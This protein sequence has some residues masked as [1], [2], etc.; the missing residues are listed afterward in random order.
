MFINR[1][2]FTNEE[3]KLKRYKREQAMYNK[4]IEHIKLCKDFNELQYNPISKMYGF[5][6]L[7]YQLSGYYSFNLSKNGGVIRLIVSENQDCTVLNLEFVT[8]DHYEDFKK[9]LK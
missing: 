9:R 2:N 1:E 8:M 3:K 4:I 5:E 7:K 6:P